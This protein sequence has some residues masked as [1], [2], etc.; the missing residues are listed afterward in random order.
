MN[1]KLNFC[2]LFI[3]VCKGLICLCL[4]LLGK[5]IRAVDQLNL[6]MLWD[7]ADIARSK[8][9]KEG[10]EWQVIKEIYFEVKL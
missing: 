3:Y 8:I 10:I 1:D 9:F 5:K 2:Q 6:A 4:L 7:R